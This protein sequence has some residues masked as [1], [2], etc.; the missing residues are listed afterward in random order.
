MS[1]LVQE[2]TRII[3]DQQ[4]SLT[5][6]QK[7]AV[8]LLSIGTFLEYFDLMLYIHMAVLLNSLFFPKDDPNSA[9][10]FIAIAY[11]ITFVFRPF[12]ALLFG[13]IGDNI[14]R[15]ITII[16]TTF[17]MATS[18]FIMATLPTYEQIG[19]TASWIISIC[20]AIQGISSLGERVGAELYLMEITKPPMQYPVVTIITV[21]ASLGSM[22]ALGLGFLITNYGFNWRYLFYFGMIIAIIGT[23]ARTKL[24]E[25]PEFANAKL[26]LRTFFDTHYIDKKI[27]K[28]DI[29]LEEKV[30][31]KTVLFYFLIQ[32]AGP[33]P[34]YF[35]YFYCG[36][37]LRNSFVYSVGDILYHNFLISI[38]QLLTTLVL[39]YLSYIIYPLKILKVRW[40]IF[41]AFIIFCPYFLDKVSTP[42]H[43]FIIQVLIILFAPDSSPASAIFYKYFPIFKRFTYSSFV[44]ALAHAIISIVTSFGFIYC[45]KYMG[46]LG[47]LC[48]MLPIVMSYGFGIFYFA[49]LEKVTSNYESY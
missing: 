34:T 19:I 20:R 21:C 33:V 26:R 9:S 11:S 23:V 41:F 16:I 27:L 31:K 8:G 22:F 13:W 46:Q 36:N 12:G 40:M 7:E 15:K 2:N 18:C 45:T 35:V 32:C 4:T 39:L 25:T 38:I 47:I 48:I 28:G 37:I 42:I 49:K 1:E 17:M 5:K 43:L 10:L 44:Y 29:I 24:R 30:Q 6:E 14:G 3:P